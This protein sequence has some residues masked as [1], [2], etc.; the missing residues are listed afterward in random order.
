MGQALD[1]KFLDGPSNLFLGERTS[2]T[3]DEELSSL[4]SFDDDDDSEGEEATAPARQARAA[5]LPVEQ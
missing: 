1:A 2:I 3:R 4:R 5:D